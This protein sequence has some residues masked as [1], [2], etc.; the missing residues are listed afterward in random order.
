MMRRISR[1]SIVL[2]LSP[3]L[4]SAQSL[5][6]LVDQIYCPINENKKIEILD[7]NRFETSY[8][9]A[10]YY[11]YLG[12][13]SQKFCTE[14]DFHSY[15][16]DMLKGKL[17]SLQNY[18]PQLSQ[19]IEYYKLALV[20]IDKEI[21]KNPSAEAIALKAE[22]MSHFSLLKDFGQIVDIGLKVEPTAKQALKKDPENVRANMVIA[23]AMVFAPRLYGGNPSKGIKT[24]KEVIKL[25]NLSREQQFNAYSG[26][27]FSYIRLKEP[28]KAQPWIKKANEV[29]PDSLLVHVLANW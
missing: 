16:Q 6:P 18:F 29:Y 3:L 23:A 7:T 4:S 14:K 21:E 26:I 5:T 13:L 19:T 10:S 22:I 25:D 8:Q 2:V 1:I 12:R 9:K 15:L 17:L 24:L 20:E 27:A 28:Q 11:Y